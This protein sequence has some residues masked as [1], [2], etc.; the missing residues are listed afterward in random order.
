LIQ[1]V[2]LGLP[3]FSVPPGP[4]GDDGRGI[5]PPGTERILRDTAARFPLIPIVMTENGVADAKDQY[6]PQFI[7]DT[8]S[9]LDKA[10]VGHDGLPPVDVRGYY[11]WSLTD[12]FEWQS[13]YAIRLGLT[14]IKYDNDLERVPRQSSDVYRDEIAARTSQR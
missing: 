14:E 5:Y 12:N 1:F 9:Y 4:V 2:F 10:K 7:V 11:H 6:R 3:Q 8:L 13:G